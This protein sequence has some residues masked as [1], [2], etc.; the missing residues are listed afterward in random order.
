MT[1]DEANRTISDALGH[2]RLMCDGGGQTN[3]LCSPR[4]QVCYSDPGVCGVS[5]VEYL[6]YFEDAAAFVRALKVACESDAFAHVNVATT[7]HV[8]PR[9]FAGAVKRFGR[10][11]CMG[12]SADPIDALVFAMAEYFKKEAK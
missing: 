3:V 9:M 8:T 7:R 2:T 12:S 4:N 6:D 5:Q 1:K 11:S 10:R